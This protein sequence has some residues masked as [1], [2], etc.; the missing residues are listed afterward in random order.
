MAR[1]R[2]DSP[3]TLVTLRTAIGILAQ[4]SL[5]SEEAYVIAAVIAASCSRDEINSS[6]PALTTA[7]PQD[8]IGAIT[9]IVVRIGARHVMHT[10]KTQIGETVGGSSGS[11]EL[12][13]GRCSAEMVS[14]RRS[15]A[16]RQVLIKGVSQRMLPTAQAR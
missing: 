16:N 7:E 2:L 8:Q 4:S 5:T 10:S 1:E 12:S 13:S 15:D 6:D 14:D 3:T 9:W 11:G